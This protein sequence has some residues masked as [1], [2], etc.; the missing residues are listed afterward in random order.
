[1]SQ[2]ISPAASSR[3]AILFV[4][5]EADLTVVAAS[6]NAADAV[7]LLPS[8]LI[9]V[10]ITELL[11]SAT[12][13]AL[14]SALRSSC[15]EAAI[16][17][18]FQRSPQL[19]EWQ[20]LTHQSDGLILLELGPLLPTEQAEALFGQHRFAIE[21]IRVS[22]SVEAACEALAT[23]IR[24]LT[25]FDRV[26]VYRFDPDWNGEV[27]AEAKAEDAHSYYGH[28][29]PAG[30]FPPQ[31]RALYTSNRVRLIPDARYT[32]SP[33]IPDIVSSAGLP[34]DLSSVMLRSV[35][36]VH[37]EYLANM[38]VVASMS[39]SVIRDGQLWGLVACHHPNPR[40]LAFR[41]LE[42]CD[43]LARGMAWHL[44]SQEHA[45]AVA[46]LADVRRLEAELT[47]GADD[48]RDYRDRIASIAPALLSL[49]RSQGL[50]ICEGQAVWSVGKV[51]TNEQ[52]LALVRWL[53]ATG[54]ER[55]TTD[56][57]PSRFT[58]ADLYRTLASG[59][60]AANLGNG[61]RI[62]FRQEWEHERTWAGEPGKPTPAPDG[63]R[64][65]PR[66]SFASWQEQVRG[67]S[68]PWTAPDLFAVAEVGALIVRIVLDHYMRQDFQRRKLESVGQMAGGLAHEL[69][70]LLQP[71][72]SMAQMALEDHQADE[73][74]SETLTVILGSANRA[75][76]IVQGILLYV[77]RSTHERRHVSLANAVASELQVLRRTLPPGICLDLRINEGAGKVRIPSSELGQIIKNLVVNAIHALEGRG[78]VTVNVDE[79]HVADA[80]AVRLEVPA[81]RYGRI[82]VSDDGP[83]IAPDLMGRIFE[84]FFT[85]KDIGQGTG[86]GLSIVRGI[87]RSSGGTIS[88]RN[89]PE[90]G[91][92]FE[93][94]LPSFIVSPA[95]VGGRRAGDAQ[96]RQQQRGDAG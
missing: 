18:R 90:G 73:E 45:A 39:V 9:R 1:V 71:I 54:E 82:L 59:I 58:P 55:L 69:N 19:A 50:A 11:V 49:T 12:T 8:A 35:S 70:S 10:P 57:L 43:L 53:H 67:R 95:P 3:T 52:I 30:D 92:A 24:R 25:G 66:K 33:I 31:A 62:W 80:Q 21:R 23:E 94:V 40:V 26:M 46:C 77:R 5:N 15:G 89:L 14:D 4:L 68:R 6:A 41:V 48:N 7:G 78:K 56:H 61:W 47:A 42:A 17:V 13:E 88:V 27:V 72:V 96:E 34:I 91:A 87:V 32:A 83:G 81:G 74:L 84:P 76:E 79:I 44:D 28:Y 22:E 86:L 63:G 85:T 16:R 37:L 38:G 29:F 51:P 2:S 64:I 60:S 20:G 75:A 93:V 36:P 65:S